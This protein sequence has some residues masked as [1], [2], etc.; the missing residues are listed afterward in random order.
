MRLVNNHFR[1]RHLELLLDGFAKVTIPL[2]VYVSSYFRHHKS[3]GSKDRL[4]LSEAIYG[5][6]R[7]QGLID[8]FV[9]QP[10]SWQKRIDWYLSNEEIIFGQALSNACLPPHVRVSFPQALFELFVDSLG[11][12]HA[13]EFCFV[14][15]FAAPVTIRVNPLKTTRENLL[16][17]W[18]DVY[19]VSP[20]KYSPFGINFRCRH[21]FFAFE[22]FRRGLFEVQD[23]GSQIIASLVDPNPGDFVLDFCAGSGGKALA[24]AH[25]L[26]SKGK[27]Y[28]HDVRAKVLQE[29]EKRFV[30]AGIQ[31]GEIV[32]SDSAKK[33]FLK[34]KMDWVLIDVPCSGSGTFRRNPDRKWTFGIAELRKLIDLQ[35][36]IFQEA[37]EFVKPGG[38][39]VYATCSVL[40]LENEEQQAYFLENFP[41]QIER[42]GFQS[43][44]VKGGMDG[45][46]GV[47]FQR[48]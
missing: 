8:Y 38:R 30:R 42:T 14:S 5:I 26:Q 16:E 39:I 17:Q 6:I 33:K 48:T 25:K 3:I 15:N 31:N 35:R 24:F 1:N 41:V 23:E 11:I 20:T 29:A 28:L 18:K 47:I 45:F 36:K 13:L 40:K 9:D 7:W 21:N 27:I 2:D 43:L 37:L 19:E 12:S 34:G 32:F 22:E 4:F 10:I 44:P 46:F